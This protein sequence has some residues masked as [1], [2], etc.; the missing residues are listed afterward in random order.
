MILHDRGRHRHDGHQAFNQASRASST[1]PGPNAKPGVPTVLLKAGDPNGSVIPYRDAARDPL[2][3]DGTGTQM[4][5][6]VS[7]MPDTAGVASVRAWIT[8]LR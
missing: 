4:P 7:H 6:L 5:P 8:A 2:P 1:P 3:L